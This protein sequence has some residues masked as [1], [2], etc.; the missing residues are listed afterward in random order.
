MSSTRRL[1]IAVGPWQLVTLAA[2]VKQ[3]NVPEAC[4]VLILQESYSPTPQLKDAMHAIAVA[5]FPD[6]KVVPVFD[7]LAACR[8]KTISGPQPI[9]NEI[10]AACGEAPSEIWMAKLNHQPERFI[11]EA[12]PEAPITLYEDGT[13]TFVDVPVL[14]PGP[15]RA[16][17]GRTL[18]AFGLRPQVVDVGDGSYLATRHYQRLTRAVLYL[19]RDLQLPEYLKDRQVISIGDD[20]LRSRIAACA[21]VP[22]LRVATASSRLRRPIVLMLGQCMARSGLIELKDEIEIYRRSVAAVLE[23]GYSVLWRD[24]PRTHQPYFDLMGDIAEPDR[25]Q[26]LQAPD[27]YPVEIFVPHLGLSACIAGVSSAILYLKDLYGIPG[28]S[29]A[30]DLR[31]YLKID[32]NFRLIQQQMA[33][34]VAALSQLPRHRTAD[35]L[36]EAITGV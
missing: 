4:D 26:R 11:L 10:R 30:D 18:R 36:R 21:Q 20:I 32:A 7:S 3:V 8:L 33:A 19:Q 9:L 12:Y 24:H 35:V 22:T 16:M 29:F 2:A 31:P 15:I 27:G 6:A 1:L 23:K 17:A 25:L 5:L 34:H 13:G 28:Y 14:G